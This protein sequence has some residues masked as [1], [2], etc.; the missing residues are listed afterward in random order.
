MKWIV[1]DT[2]EKRVF[3]INPSFRRFGR[4]LYGVDF[5]N[6]LDLVHID[7]RPQIQGHSFGKEGKGQ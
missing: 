6:S 4:W 5:S 2:R 7:H 3:K 1:S